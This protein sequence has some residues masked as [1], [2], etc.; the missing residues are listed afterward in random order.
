[1]K[2]ILMILLVF[3]SFFIINLGVTNSIN[4]IVKTSNELNI[5]IVKSYIEHNHSFIQ[6]EKSFILDVGT[7]TYVATP[8]ILDT[9]KRI[10]LSAKFKNELFYKAYPKLYICSHLNKIKYD[11]IQTYIC[12]NKT[13]TLTKIKVDDKTYYIIIIVNNEMIKEQ[14]V[15]VRFYHL[16]I[17]LIMF[18]IIGFMNE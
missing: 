15:S 3:L 8:I 5:G 12:F 6:E 9:Q 16:I 14:F 4:N 10:I 17:A 7:L 2:K 18:F 11:K 13:I 1:M